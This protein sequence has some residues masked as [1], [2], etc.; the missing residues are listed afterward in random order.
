MISEIDCVGA[1][2]LQVCD[3]FFRLRE[4]VSQSAATDGLSG[5]SGLSE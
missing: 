1:S 3:K 4:S 5:L 2:N